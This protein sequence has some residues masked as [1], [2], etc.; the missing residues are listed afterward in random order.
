MAATYAK[1]GS[2]LNQSAQ[3]GPRPK[4]RSTWTNAQPKATDEIKQMPWALLL[5]QKGNGVK[6]GGVET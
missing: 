3:L 5:T 4:Q 1:R 2:C 6:T